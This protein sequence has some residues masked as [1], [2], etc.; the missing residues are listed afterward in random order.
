MCTLAIQWQK[1]VVGLFLHLSLG[2]VTAVALVWLGHCVHLDKKMHWLQ[3]STI[4]ALSNSE[5]KLRD[6]DSKL[7]IPSDSSCCPDKHTL[8]N[9]AFFSEV[10]ARGFQDSDWADTHLHLS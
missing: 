3:E 5:E 9:A 6:T 2:V 4:R 8:R 10:K 7:L 1:P